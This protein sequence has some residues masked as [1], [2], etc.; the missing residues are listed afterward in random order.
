MSFRN[1]L[2]RPPSVY[3]LIVPDCTSAPV[4]VR[5]SRT[6]PRYGAGQTGDPRRAY[7]HSCPGH[8]GQ[9][10]PRPVP[11][12][13][14]K[15]RCASLCAP[16]R[17][18]QAP[19]AARELLAARG[20]CVERTRGRSHWRSPAVAGLGPVVAVLVR[21]DLPQLT[22]GRDRYLLPAAHRARQ[23]APPLKW[24]LPSLH[25]SQSSA[26]SRTTSRGTSCT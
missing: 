25:L 17:G 19:R 20:A 24:T 10:R 3:G 16:A 2:S 26:C 6:G 21:A 4:T 18:A 7:F 23:R 12:A 5:Y 14:E 1:E 8:S 13:A 11:F 22:P 9:M 15:R